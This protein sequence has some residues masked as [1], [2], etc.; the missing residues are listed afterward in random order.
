MIE[1][2]LLF[3]LILVVGI[4]LSAEEEVDFNQHIRPI[5]SGKCFACHGPDEKERKAKLRLDMCESAI[6][7]HGGIRARLQW[8]FWGFHGHYLWCYSIAVQ[9][10]LASIEGSEFLP[11]ILTEFSGRNIRYWHELSKDGVI[12]ATS[13]RGRFWGRRKCPW[14]PY[15][16]R[17]G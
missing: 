4:N 12:S 10:G 7:Y 3:S 2:L 9:P 11:Q 13:W 15:Y 1:R 8:T 14:Y 5:L 16:G 17:I 6:A